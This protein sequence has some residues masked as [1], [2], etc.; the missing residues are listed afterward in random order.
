M[1]LLLLPPPPPPP[2]LLQPPP[3]P[4]PPPPCTRLLCHCAVALEEDG[5]DGRGHDAEAGADSEHDVAEDLGRRKAG[6]RHGPLL[7][8]VGEVVVARVDEVIPVVVVVIVVGGGGGGG[9]VVGV[10]VV[11][12]GGVVVVMVVSGRGVGKINNN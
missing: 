4:P 9:V 5:D 7:G 1:V 2:L 10:V 12:G 3:P 11:V 6:D 8:P